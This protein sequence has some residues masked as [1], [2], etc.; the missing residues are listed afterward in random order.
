MSLA[1]ETKKDIRVARKLWL[2]WWAVLLLIPIC[3]LGSWLF[4]H[5]GRLNL[6]LPTFNTVG[7]LGVLLVVKRGGR[8]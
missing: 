6:A 1:T 8:P 4:D 7:V 3:T 5:Y 2:P